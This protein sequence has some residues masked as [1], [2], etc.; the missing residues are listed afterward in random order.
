MED[1][2]QVFSYLRQ[3]GGGRLLVIL[4]FYKEEAEFKLPGNIGFKEKELLIS[5]YSP[6]GSEDLDSLMLKPFE[7]R[8]YRLS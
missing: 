2:E 1:S 6:G 5:N 7:A 3:S 4:N 8:V